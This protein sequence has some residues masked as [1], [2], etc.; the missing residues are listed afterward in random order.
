MPYICLDH[1]DLPWPETPYAQLY[2]LTTCRRIFLRHGGITFSPLIA[3]RHRHW[4][5]PLFD[6]RGIRLLRA[7][8]PYKFGSF[9]QVSRMTMDGSCCLYLVVTTRLKM[10]LWRQLLTHERGRYM[11]MYTCVYVCMYVCML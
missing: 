7:S 4:G 8:L 5:I 1:G 3:I 11:Y 6:N 10:S 9:G 2:L